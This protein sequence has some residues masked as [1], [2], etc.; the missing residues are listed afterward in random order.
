MTEYT[1]QDTQSAAPESGGPVDPLVRNL[2]VKAGVMQMG[3][4]IEWGSDTRLMYQAA[5][6]IEK[7]REE[8]EH[9]AKILFKLDRHGYINTWTP[10]P[11]EESQCESLSVMAGDAWRNARKVL[12]YS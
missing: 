7:L 8:L 1:D 9:C 2:R 3:E 11:D 6:R 12:G 10:D 4:K 5:D